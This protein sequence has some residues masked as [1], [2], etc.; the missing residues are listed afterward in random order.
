MFE[1]KVYP[2]AKH[3]K[4]KILK[5]SVSVLMKPSTPLNAR[6]I[7]GLHQNATHAKKNI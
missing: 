7:E 4:A 5:R 2:T 1:K 6:T 3:P